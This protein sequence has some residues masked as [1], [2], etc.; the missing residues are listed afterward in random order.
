MSFIFFE[1]LE[2]F[3]TLQK[4]RCQILSTYSIF[5]LTSV[6]RVILEN[7]LCQ[8]HVNVQLCCLFIWF[9]FHTCFSFKGGLFFSQLQVVSTISF[10]QESNQLLNSLEILTSLNASYLDTLKLDSRLCVL[11]PIVFL[12]LYQHRKFVYYSC[13]R[14]YNDPQRYQVP[15][16]EPINVILYGKIAFV[17][18]MKLRIL[19]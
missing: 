8:I 6:F 13:S 16:L 11:L 7:S 5:F 12:A 18:V 19:R 15:I 1:L 2:Y 3:I 10:L 14:I 4:L 9:Y 17:Y